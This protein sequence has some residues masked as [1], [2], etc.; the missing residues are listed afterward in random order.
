MAYRSK[1]TKMYSSGNALYS[2][3]GFYPCTRINSNSQI[4][5]ESIYY[6]MFNF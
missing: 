2:T 4:I 1:M 5:S 6:M 3:V